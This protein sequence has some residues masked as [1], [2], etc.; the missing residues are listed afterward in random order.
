MF[1]R[2]VSELTFLCE[3]L[4]KRVVS[5]QSGEEVMAS[6]RQV[7]EAYVV[8]VV[9]DV[10]VDVVAVAVAVAVAAAAAAAAAAVV[11]V[12]VVVAGVSN[13][14]LRVCVLLLLH[15]LSKLRLIHSCSC[16]PISLARRELPGRRDDQCIVA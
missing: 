15:I 3:E 13:P 7:K 11:V 8:V 16:P 9:V 14:V 2:K 1:P 4:Q 5:L 6:Q 10:D 12:V